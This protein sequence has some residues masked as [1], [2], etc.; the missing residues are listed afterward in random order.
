MFFG[1]PPE[2]SN[3][4]APA[5]SY[6]YSPGLISL[7]ETNQY[8]MS[9]PQSERYGVYL[10]FEHKLQGDQLVAYADVFHQR[11][12]TRLEPF[13]LFTGPFQ[14]MPFINLAIPPHAA[15]PTL[16]GPAL[17]STDLPPGAYNPFNP[18]Q[19]IIGGSSQLRFVELGNEIFSDKTDATL[20][21]AGL[22]GE[23]L[24][25]GSWGFDTAARYSEVTDHP[26]ALHIL[27]A[28]RFQ[29]MLNAADPFFDPTSPEFIGQTTPYNPF[30]DYRRAPASNLRLLTLA[31]VEPELP[32]TSRVGTVDLS[33]YTTN[34]LDLPAGGVAFAFGAEGRHEEISWEPDSTF[35]SGDALT[36]PV[37]NPVRSSRDSSA[38]YAEVA[39]PLFSAM[40]H[41]AGFHSL[42][43]TGAARFENYFNND[44]NV[45]VP[46]VG[47]RW[48]PFDDTLTLRA[49]WGEGFREP[50]GLELF[51]PP[52]PT[53]EFTREVPFTP[54]L[55][56]ASPNLQPED[57]RNFT[58]GVVYT[59]KF[60]PGLT[61]S[62][63]LFNI[64]RSGVVIL[65]SAQEVLD[66]E[67]AGQL[68]PGEVVVRDAQGNLLR[69]DIPYENGG[70]QKARGLDASLSYQLQTSVGTF[71]WRTEATFLD[72][73]K[74]S[75][76]AGSPQLELRS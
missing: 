54:V 10:T 5:T 24:F 57:S 1:S 12:N 55:L 27:S 33:I 11:V 43:I 60:L 6:R 21:T 58:A 52:F 15:G 74:K 14:L 9:F 35:R 45:L 31:L 71:T 30:V 26:K 41:I 38:V 67:A 18:F 37:V 63:D 3:G 36:A 56:V 47:L 8:S 42:E 39:I 59:P 73:F 44:T 51:S 62:V 28:S 48:Q 32:A 2:L 22:K 70:V 75:A 7:F 16:G 69:V 29:R 13:P 49:T 50:S 68:L 40:Q 72:S 61:T 17:E 76:A 66:R 4:N 20:F 65:P 25:G 64:E 19:Q 23:K 34:L 53:V 46:K